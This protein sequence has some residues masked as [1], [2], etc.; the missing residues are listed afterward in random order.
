MT[1][2]T[3]EPAVESGALAFVRRIRWRSSANANV[4]STALFAVMNIA[5]L[6]M[7]AGPAD[8]SAVYF[9]AN[10]QYAVQLI[11]IP[12][13]YGVYFEHRETLRTIPT[14]GLY[15]GAMVLSLFSPR[16]AL[17]PLL[18]LR[19]ALLKFSRASGPQ[20]AWAVAGVGAIAL[21]KATG[22]VSD[23]YVASA[24]T[25]YL[26]FLF[27][28]QGSVAL[29]QTWTMSW[30][31]LSNVFRRTSLDYV[32]LLAPLVMN[33]VAYRYLDPTNYIH[34]QKC[35]TSLAVSG[36]VT[37]YIERRIFDQHLV[38]GG[39][40]DPR[41][42]IAG[43]VSLSVLT[44]LGALL[45]AVFVGVPPHLFASVALCAAVA[46]SFSM[47][48]S[49]LRFQRSPDALMRFA[50]FWA[51]S[52]A[53]FLG[54]VVATRVTVISLLTMSALFTAYMIVTILAPTRHARV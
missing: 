49:R 24:A 26:I 47:L 33:V 19:M 36:P 11:S 39:A 20:W 5:V 27:C 41:A 22:H 51:V 8:S 14:S 32:L 43:V 15:F 25:T 34:F 23:I 40:H 3:T 38:D 9:F 18:L 37:S 21:Y 2:H 16:T 29:P 53:V 4:A 35:M 46:T 50:A 6:K 1:A 13:F 12:L 17:V 30:S 52:N 10:A 45:I 28:G 7:V 48:L 54:A 42:M 31:R 44:I